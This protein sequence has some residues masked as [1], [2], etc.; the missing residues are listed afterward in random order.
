MVA[1]ALRRR[2]QRDDCSEDT[3]VHGT[4]SV[5]RGSELV[6]GGAVVADSED[7]AVGGRR[8]ECTV[9]DRQGRG[10]VDD[11][12]VEVGGQGGEHLPEP[13][14]AQQLGRVRRDRT[15]GDDA[16]AVHCGQLDDVVDFGST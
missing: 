5:G 4:E 12:V 8:D 3:G 7:D 10:R 11:D 15:G 16:E 14:G 6:G 9:S 1:L 13:S 2:R